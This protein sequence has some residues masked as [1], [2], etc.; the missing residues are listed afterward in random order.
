[1]SLPVQFSATERAEAIARL[2]GD[3]GYKF[4]I[5]DLG[6]L[7]HD[8]LASMSRAST[9]GEVLKLSRLWQALF[10]YWSILKDEPERL[11]DAL[12]ADRADAAAM[13]NLPPG[14]DGQ[15]ASFLAA[16]DRWVAETKEKE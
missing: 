2:T 9:D 14:L 1:M 12:E 3:L 7:Q 11:K 16:I 15:R 13:T 6:N 10:R 8:V 4:L 5:E